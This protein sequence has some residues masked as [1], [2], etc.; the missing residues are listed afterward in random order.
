MNRLLYP[1]S[2]LRWERKRSHTITLLP[3]IFVVHCWPMPLS[4]PLTVDEW[5]SNTMYIAQWSGRPTQHEIHSSRLVPR[6]LMRK[7]FN[8]VN[9]GLF[10]NHMMIFIAT[11]GQVMVYKTI[12]PFFPFTPGNICQTEVDSV[13]FSPPC[14]NLQTP[15][16]CAH[17]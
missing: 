17:M 5:V 8:T 13:L 4:T 16:A 15:S 9:L 10:F 6:R 12:L 1:A 7:A 2:P 11:E 3:G 14:Q